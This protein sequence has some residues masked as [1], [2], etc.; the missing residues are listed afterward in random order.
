MENWGPLHKSNTD[1]TSWIGAKVDPS[2]VIEA[3]HKFGV[4]NCGWEVFTS[5]QIETAISAAQAICREYTIEDILGHDDIAP[6]RKSDP[7]PAWDM[8]TFKAKVGEVRATDEGFA[9]R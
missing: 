9:A 7:G 6:G 2:K 5:A 4:P 8:E 3:R 1:W